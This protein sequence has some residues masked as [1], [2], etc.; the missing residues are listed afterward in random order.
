[1]KKFFGQ[2]LGLK[3]IISL[4]ITGLIYFL[5]PISFR[6]HPPCRLEDKSLCIP[7]T[8]STTQPLFN[9]MKLAGFTLDLFKL[10]IYL[11]IFYLIVLVVVSL[12]INQ[13]TKKQK[14]ENQI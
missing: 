8:I 6:F 3:S 7:T 9:L 13:L 12:I 2:K 10:I 5:V 11:I 4:V 1:M 14:I